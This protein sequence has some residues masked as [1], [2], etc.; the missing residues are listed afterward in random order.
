M[1]GSLGT[2]LRVTL[3]AAGLA[4]CSSWTPDFTQFKPLPD[5]GSFLP[6]NSGTYTPPA[7]ARAQKPVAPAD[8]VDAQGGCAGVANASAEATTQ[9][10]DA[11]AAPAVPH[12]IGL[13]MTECDVVH[14][15]GQ[16]QSVDI[17]ANERGERKVTMK[18]AGNDRAGIY[19]FVAGRLTSFERGPEPPAPPKPQ[20]PQKPARKKPPAT[21]RQQGQQ[22]PT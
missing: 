2:G 18:F 21:A 5:P 11:T 1:K 12:G 8:L 16:P 13:D 19:E 9:G 17:G 7:V 22:P 14:A 20:K 3:L 15:I 10:S 4:G 6:S